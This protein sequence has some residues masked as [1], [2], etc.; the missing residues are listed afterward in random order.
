M[1]PRNQ[2]LNAHIDARLAAYATLAGVALAAPAVSKADIVYSGVVNYSVPNDFGGIYI[3]FVTGQTGI[4]AGDVPGWNWNPFGGATGQLQFYWNTPA[5]PNGGLSLDTTT[6]A[7]LPPNTMVGPAN[8][9]IAST[10]AAATVGWQAGADAYL[11]IRLVNSQTLATNF[12]WVHFNTTGTTGFPAT[13]VE[14]A[15]ENT[16]NSILTGQTTVPEPSTTA[17]LG[18]MAA[19]ALGVRAWRKR[20][21][22]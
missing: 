13:I 15:F 16:G 1:S 14:Y 11:G 2:K 17:L 21:A 3:N 20:K 6:Y 10:N 8:T 4:A 7:V 9:Y 22:A 18:V 5:G 19:G 12:G